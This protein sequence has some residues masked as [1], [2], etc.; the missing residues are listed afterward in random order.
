MQLKRGNFIHAKDCHKNEQ[1]GKITTFLEH[2]V[3]I[4]AEIDSYVI[5]KEELK[6]Q[7]YT[8]PPYKKIKYYQTQSNK[9]E[10]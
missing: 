1:S 10:T 4:D 8:F 5:R 3:V 2:T 9:D 7:G 6:K